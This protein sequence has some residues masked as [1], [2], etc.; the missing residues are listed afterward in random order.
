MA[1][2]L[3][4]A[5]PSGRYLFIESKPDTETATGQKELKNLTNTFGMKYAALAKLADIRDEHGAAIEVT[6]HGFGRH[7]YVHMMLENNV[8]LVTVA[9]LIGDTPTIVQ[10]HYNEWVA[11]SHAK[12]E[13]EVKRVLAAAPKQW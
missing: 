1:A 3:K 5:N 2:V 8:P 10:K 9:E 6:T 12:T 7:S 13:R 11:S 4:G